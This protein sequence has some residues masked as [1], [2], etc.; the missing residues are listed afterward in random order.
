MVIHKGAVNA[1]AVIGKTD[2]ANEEFGHRE[3][4]CHTHK[5]SIDS[6]HSGFTDYNPGVTLGGWKSD[7]LFIRVGGERDS[8]SGV[9]QLQV[10]FCPPVLSESR[11]LLC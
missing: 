5:S 11:S 2:L 10:P 6:L 3:V 8:H 4:L 1:P 9:I 7:E